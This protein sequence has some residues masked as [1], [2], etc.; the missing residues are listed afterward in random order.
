M[1]PDERYESV[2]EEIL[3]RF[4]E[5][6]RIEPAASPEKV[7]A[8]LRRR[9]DVDQQFDARF[10]DPLTTAAHQPG[11]GVQS[12]TAAPNGESSPRFRIIRFHASGGL[13]EVFLAEDLELHRSVALKQIQDRH[14]GSAESRS[15][16]VREA[17]I[18]GKL[19]HPG[20]VPVYGL[21]QHADGRPYYAMRFIQGDS[22]KEAIEQFHDPEAAH[23]ASGERRLAL[24]KL[25]RR[26]L[27]V[28]NAV[29]Y[30]H[31]RGVLHRDLKPGNVMVGRFGETQVVDWG[32]AKVLDLPERTSSAILQ[33]GST[34]G[35]TETSP[36]S[37]IGTPAYMSPE[38][39]EGRHDDVG[40]ASDVY[41]LGAT[42]Y[43]VL[44]G[45]APKRD[46]PQDLPGIEASGGFAP[47]R[48]ICPGTD[49]ALEAICLKA[50]A[51][52]P[53]ARYP[54]PRA[55][56]EDLER[57]LADE[58]VS[59]WPEPLAVRARRWIRKHRTLVITAA[60][61]ALVGLAALAVAY[62][63]EASLNR[64]LIREKAKAEGNEQSAIAAITRFRDVVANEPELKNTPALD[65]LRKRLLK[66][67]LQFFRGLRDRLQAQGDT[68]PE[69]LA[70]LAEAGF[71]LGTL[72]YEIG[73]QQDALEAHRAALVIL[74]DLA[75]A[76]PEDVVYR[77]NLA[78]S[79]NSVGIL[80]HD[81]G[82]PAEAEAAHRA[83]LALRSDLAKLRPDSSGLKSDLAQTHNNLGV[84]LKDVGRLAQALTEF[85]AAIAI[86]D[87]LAR[88]HPEIEEYVRARADG[89]YNIGILLVDLGRRAEALKALDAAS[90]TY[91]GQ[92]AAHP[93][94]V[95]LESHLAQSLNSIG[96]ARLTTAK[97]AEALAAFQEAG[98]ILKTL[99]STHPSNITVQ[100]LLARTHQNLAMQWIAT[101]KPAEALAEYEAALS[102]NRLLS[103]SNPTVTEF[104]REQARNLFNIALL[105]NEHGQ[106]ARALEA[107]Q[108]ARAIEQHL[109]DANPTVTEFQ[110]DLAYSYSQI[111]TL[112][113]DAGRPAE[114]LEAYE[115]ALGIQRRLVETNPGFL[116][117]QSHLARTHHSIGVLLRLGGQ[118]DRALEELQAGLTLRQALA[119]SDP[120]VM[121]YQTD[122]AAS[123]NEIG[124]LNRDAENRL[125]AM[126]AYQASLEITRRLAHEYPETP[127]F[128]SNLGCTLNNMAVLDIDARRFSDARAKLREAVEWQRLA[129]AAN[130]RNSTYRQFLAG[131]LTNLA[132][133]AGGLG[134]TDEES[135][136]QHEL[137]DLN[138]RDPR[139]ADLD[140]RLA[141]V[142][143][144]A[145]A[146]NP[147]ERLALAERA[148][149]TK[150]YTAAARLWSE[151]I[152]FAPE[153]AADRQAQIRYNA[154]CAAALAAN[155]QPKPFPVDGKGKLLADEA[156]IHLRAQAL[157]WLKAEL[158]TWT[159]LVESASPQQAAAIAQTLRHWLVDPDLAGVRDREDLARLPETEGEAWRSLWD[160]VDQLLT[161][162][163]RP[164]SSRAEGTAK[165]ELPVDPFA[166]P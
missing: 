112:L 135:D 143:E 28:C 113:R 24:Q 98:R 88:A 75:E 71:A 115:T 65:A 36:G 23:R 89:Q 100:S 150:Q 77:A 56:A 119:E 41:S 126:A 105:L 111:G 123:H 78:Q 62:S 90:S 25:L 129:L 3:E 84:L 96:N 48:R 20:I 152:E 1:P 67:P 6:R 114:A 125:D 133:A 86:S 165:R 101:G 153:L 92:A 51:L 72:E 64:Q 97:P 22:L 55:L 91:R 57:W 121:Q 69:S 160:S 142:L 32:L 54:S 128:A 159:T 117:F 21:G 40:P 8:Q 59:A 99:A 162:V 49:R 17:E 12:A 93:G 118:T 116:P 156:S 37:V 146:K 9:I 66:E 35:S 148:Y 85:E 58:P 110:S 14:L 157:D 108:A 163:E 136:A 26:F 46:A 33:H 144:G 47:P 147:G 106:Q 18:T 166:S 82:Q 73:D 120:H 15:R 141:A 140:I 151:S 70:R 61:A 80:L 42:L 95:E 124:I 38:Q 50:M 30:A 39:A 103:Q 102:I 29:E 16:F 31:S 76:H 11:S 87:T 13:G 107:I 145:A 63:R 139:L 2:L 104:Q 19:E 81:T 122:L 94:N 164:P 68:R 131:H 155:S 158:A 137:E 132:L 52:E 34:S 45:R 127:E 130:L 4:E 109:A 53:D 60:S 154:A 5:L 74:K 10:R 43:T 44:T 7:L 79:Y 27:D 83:A 161:K 134:L 138:A 149:Q